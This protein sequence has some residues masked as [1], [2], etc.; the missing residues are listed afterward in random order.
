MARPPVFPLVFGAT[1]KRLP[2][3][4]ALFEYAPEAICKT[5]APALTAVFARIEI[6]Q[7]L[8]PCKNARTDTADPD[9]K[10]TPLGTRQLK[11]RDNHG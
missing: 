8:R 3:S 7:S 10:S 2:V 1:A 6:E 5:S 4:S 11:A 9:P